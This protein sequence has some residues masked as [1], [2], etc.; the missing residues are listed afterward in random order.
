MPLSPSFSIAVSADPSAITLEDTSTGSDVN[1][2]ARQI[3]LTKSDGTP[4]ATDIPWPL[5]VNPITIN[6]LTIDIALS[7]LVEW[8]DIN[9]VVVNSISQI[10]AFTGYG[11]DEFY[12]LI[13]TMSSNP[14][15]YL[16]DTVFMENFYK[17][18]SLLD[19]AGFAIS[20]AGDLGGAQNVINQSNDLIQNKTMNF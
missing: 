15:D 14:T 12:S 19:A 11:E 5:V 10:Y 20:T 3:T 16:R 1:I 18:R 6:P 4:L 8:I 13:Q 9:N 17:L 2:V 7:I